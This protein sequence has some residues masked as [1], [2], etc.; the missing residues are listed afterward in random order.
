M[1]CMHGWVSEREEGERKR[2]RVRKM[3]REREGEREGEK[4]RGRERERIEG[5]EDY[6]QA[7][8]LSPPVI[9]ILILVNHSWS[10]SGIAVSA[11]SS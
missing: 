3:E 7:C 8:A 6:K 2:E 1:A 5:A 9:S 10:V 4:E 11:A